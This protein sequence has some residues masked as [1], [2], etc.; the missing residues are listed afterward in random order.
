MTRNNAGWTKHTQIPSSSSNGFHASVSIS[1]DGKVI[2]NGKEVSAFANG[3]LDQNIC[4]NKP[5]LSLE[6]E[7]GRGVAVSGNGLW[8]ACGAPLDGPEDSGSVYIVRR[9]GETWYEYQYL[10]D[11]QSTNTSFGYSLSFSAKGKVRAIGAPNDSPPTGS[12]FHLSKY[13]RLLHKVRIQ[14][15]TP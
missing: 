2:V 1:D 7:Y 15:F 8:I 14:D 10:E 6:E 5:G 3:E 11:T 9:D 12:V 4:F 13:Q